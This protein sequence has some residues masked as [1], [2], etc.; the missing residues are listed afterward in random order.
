M[1]DGTRYAPEGRIYGIYGATVFGMQAVERTLKV[2]L[3]E[4]IIIELGQ[5]TSEMKRSLEYMTLG[6]MIEKLESLVQP[7]FTDEC[8]DLRNYV[9]NRNYVAHQFFLDYV[10]A[11]GDAARDDKAEAFLR[12]CHRESVLALHRIEALARELR[13]PEHM[14]YTERR[15]LELM[16]RLKVEPSERIVVRKLQDA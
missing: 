11:V 1:S 4:T 5:L 8:G 13:L 6:N 16:E 9:K 7:R 15:D 3:I 12:L 2:A 14:A 10:D